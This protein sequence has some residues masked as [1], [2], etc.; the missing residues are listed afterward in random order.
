[1]NS[2]KGKR[3]I[4]TGSSPG[5]DAAVTVRNR[6]YCAVKTGRQNTKSDNLKGAPVLRA[7]HYRPMKCKK[8]HISDDATSQHLTILLSASKAIS[9]AAD[10]ATLLQALLTIMIEQAGAQRVFLLKPQ[11]DSVIL[12]ARAQTTSEGVMVEPVHCEADWDD[13][14]RP[15]I[16]AVIQTHKLLYA[17]V[18]QQSTADDTDTYFQRLSGV[19]ALCLPVIKQHRLVAIFYIEISGNDERLNDE[20]L[21]VL[22]IMAAH[23]AAAIEAARL[24]SG[25]DE[26]NQQ[27]L[28]LERALRLADTSLALGE[29]I[30]RTGSWRWEL[31]KKTLVCSEEFCHIFDLDP[32]HRTISFTDFIARI[33]PDDQKPVLDQV[34]YAVQ[35][36][37]AIN[38]EYRILKAD[39]SVLYLTGQGCPVFGADKLVDY[40]GT[41]NDVTARRASDNAL[42]VAQDDLARMCRITTIGQ[43]TSSI[44][45]EI[46]QPLMSIV[47]NAGAGLRWL[48]RS[49]PDLQQVSNSLQAIASEG[50]RAGQIVQSLRTLTKNTKALLSVLDIH[51]VLK[52]IL[53]IARREIER[54]HV[55]LELHLDAQLS[56]IRGDMVQLQQVMLNLLMNAIEAMSEISNRPRVLTLSTFTE[57]DQVILIKV[58]DTGSGISDEIKDHLF[59]AFYTTKKDGMGMGLAI[60]HSIV[61]M[62]GGELSAAPR[63]PVGSV[64]SFSIPLV[65]N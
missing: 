21:N 15:L 51:D 17:N 30:S 2:S 3:A 36:E 52:C 37:T 49:E 19:I 42:R 10:Y 27:R 18:G 50:Q 32:R 60:C 43:L 9:E 31:D 61:E 54:R 33:H 58:E 65:K 28:K 8:L 29:Q 22:E 64:F 41:V 48:H 55:S 12:E 1:M 16:N 62:H 11:D 26:M 63:Q 4:L 45:H 23:A 53:A 47:A 59:E 24:Q 38:V 56:H 40:V 35:M 46:N 44:A 6:P 20:Y 7:L 57:D 39:G 5:F 14:P 25:I 13:L 34:H